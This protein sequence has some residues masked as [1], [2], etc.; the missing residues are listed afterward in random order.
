[1]ALSNA[2]KQ[3]RYRERALKDPDG[4]LLTR[5]QVMLSPSA[6]ATLNRLCERTGKT[7]REIVESA[8]MALDGYAVT[9]TPAV[10]PVPANTA[11]AGVEDESRLYD[12]GSSVS[13]WVLAHQAKHAIRQISRK[14]PNAKQALM[15]VIAV[16]E[17][18]EKAIKGL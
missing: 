5:L 7:K 1:M 6:D 10:E 12:E 9:S 18:Q 3:R 8:I 13:A 17:R 14:D 15:S 16:M 4:L 2:E 11:P